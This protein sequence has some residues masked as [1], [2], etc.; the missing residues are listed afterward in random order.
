MANRL[1]RS[2][3]L[4]IFTVFSCC[5]Y[6][7]LKM[8]LVTNSI[9]FSILWLCLRT[10]AGLP[11]QHTVSAGLPEQ[12][13]IL[14]GENA[15]TRYRHFPNWAKKIKLIRLDCGEVCDTSIQPIR[16]EKYYDY[17]DKNVDCLGLFESP[18][19]EQTTLQDDIHPETYRPPGR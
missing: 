3:K 2:Y 6:C 10:V 17:I 18:V 11:E 16:K 5:I 7:G 13:D 8:K 15:E 12:T 4:Y 1:I 19:L 14:C 9:V